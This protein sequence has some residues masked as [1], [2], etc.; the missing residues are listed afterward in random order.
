MGSLEL[1]EELTGLA[2]LGQKKKISCFKLA[3]ANLNTVNLSRQTA[4]HSA[5]ETGQIK[6]VQFLIEHDVDATRKDIFGHTPLDLAKLL[7]RI[8][9][10]SIL[11]KY[12]E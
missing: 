2:R 4:L 11:V 10:E 5:V 3:G 1:G 9:I 8:E 6:V 12:L 7:N